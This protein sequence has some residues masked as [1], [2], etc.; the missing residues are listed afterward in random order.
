MTK[1]LLQSLEEITENIPILGNIL[2]LLRLNIRRWPTN[3]TTKYGNQHACN[4]LSVQRVEMSCDHKYNGP[5]CSNLIGQHR[6]VSHFDL[7]TSVYVSSY[8]YRIQ[9]FRWE[10]KFSLVFKVKSAKSVTPPPILCHKQNT[11]M[12]T[13]V[14]GF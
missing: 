11:I 8:F 14:F 12:S 4:R 10:Q 2:I 13:S 1:H 3:E 6:L 9:K 5:H 7:S